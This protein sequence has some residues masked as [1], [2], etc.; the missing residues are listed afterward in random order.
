MQSKFA[1]FVFLATLTLYFGAGSLGAVLFAGAWGRN[2]V[3]LDI[4]LIIYLIVASIVVVSSLGQN[5]KQPFLSV[6]LQ[7]NIKRIKQKEIYISRKYSI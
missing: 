3:D 5:K 1:L 2:T 6:T 7:T 4:S